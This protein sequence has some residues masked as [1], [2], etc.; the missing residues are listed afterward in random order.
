MKI[1]I[2]TLKKVSVNFLNG[3]ISKVILDTNR[4][5][6]YFYLKLYNYS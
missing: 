4:L 5:F 3:T 1:L 6:N 2:E